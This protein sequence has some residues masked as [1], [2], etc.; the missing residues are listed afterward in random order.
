MSDDLKSTPDSP[1]A[2]QPKPRRKRKA[3]KGKGD[4]KPVESG[5][6][7]ASVNP[8]AIDET[9]RGLR[10]ENRVVMRHNIALNLDSFRAAPD[11]F[12]ARPQ[13]SYPALQEVPPPFL[14]VIIPTFNGERHL[15][16]VL[17]ALRSQIFG[18]FEVIVIDDAS[19]DD[20]AELVERTLS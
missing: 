12:V 19:S 8:I 6:K 4:A 14:S 9:Y 2:E 15:P 20:S 17:N 16:T 18:D 1:G 11:D 3:P 10:D 7:S 5:E 13:R